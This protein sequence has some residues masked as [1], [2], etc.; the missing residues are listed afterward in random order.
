[1]C[2]RDSKEGL[3]IERFNCLD[4]RNESVSE[5]IGEGIRKKLPFASIYYTSGAECCF[6]LPFT[7]FPEDSSII[8]ELK[9]FK[10]DKNK[11]SVKCWSYVTA[12]TLCYELSQPEERE[13]GFRMS[14]PLASKPVDFTTKT[15]VNYNW[16]TNLIKNRDG[17]GKSDVV[18]YV[19]LV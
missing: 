4:I 9:H 10:S 15:W 17:S 3:I 16:R 12:K 1:M 11:T 18:V 13:E 7:D 2:I 6:Q 19:N 8:I 14:L 5:E